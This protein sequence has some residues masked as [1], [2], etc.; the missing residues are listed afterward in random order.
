M[1]SI[2]AVKHHITPAL[3]ANA[4]VNGCLKATRLTMQHAVIKDRP[5]IDV[6]TTSTPII[7]ISI[8]RNVLMN[9]S[10][11]VSR[12]AAARLYV[13]SKLTYTNLTYTILFCGS[14]AEPRWNQTG[15]KVEPRGFEVS[16]FALV[17]LTRWYAKYP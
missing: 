16:F 13:L 17:Q 5:H 6:I 8:S 1:A 9:F 3:I 14:E 15:S 2:I 11:T 12:A 7:C 10:F 4:I